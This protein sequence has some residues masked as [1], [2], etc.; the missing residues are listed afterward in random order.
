VVRYALRPRVS[1][2]VREV[3]VLR[4]M[5]SHPS[6]ARRRGAAAVGM[7]LG[8]DPAAADDRVAAVV[9][10]AHADVREACVAKHRGQFVA[11]V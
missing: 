5:P 2:L 4:A 11:A 1:H 6:V 10:R 8:A 7:S 9:Q 3:R